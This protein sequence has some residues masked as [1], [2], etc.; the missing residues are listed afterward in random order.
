[1]KRTLPFNFFGAAFLAAGLFAESVSAQIRFSAGSP[2]TQ[3]FDS[4]GTV[5]NA[6]TDNITL[7]G[8]YASKTSGGATVTGYRADSGASNTGAL[9]SFGVTGVNPVTDRALGSVASGTPG[10]FAYGIRFQ[11]D[12][13]LAITNITLG[14]AGEQWRNGGNTA[15]QTLAFSYLISNNPI[16]SSDAANAT[17]WTAFSPLSFDSPTVGANAAALDGNAATNRQ[18]LAPTLLPG[19]VVFPG[20]EIF[21]RWYDINDAGNDH[22]MAVDDLTI[23]FSTVVAVTNPPAIGPGG[24]PQS[25]TNNAGTRAIF[26]VT[27]IGMPL[28]Y[29]WHLNGN[30]LMDGGKISGATSP[31]LTVSNVLSGD[32]GDYTVTVYNSADSV[33]SSNALLTV[34][35]PAVNTQPLSRTNIAGD[36]ASFSVTAAGTGAPLSYQWRFNGTDIPGANFSFLT[37]ESVQSTNQGGYTVVVGNND[38]T[39]SYTTSAVANLTLLATPVYN[40]ARWNFNETN[41]LVVTG[42]SAS[43][44]SGTASLVKGTTAGFTSGTSSDPAG[45]PGAANSGWNTTSYPAQ[46]TSNRTAGVQFKV[47]TVGYQD[48][49]V[50]WEQKHSA[51]AS[52]YA[53]LQYTTDGSSFVDGDLITMT[54]TNGDWVFYVS[55]LAAA[56]GVNN[57][58]NFAIRIVAEWE[59]TATGNNNSNYVGSASTYS[60][61]GTIRFDLLGV[62]GNLYHAPTLAPTTIRN[63][64][65]TTL[66]YSGGAGSRFV[67]LKSANVATALSVWERAH[68]NYA[69]PGTFT[70]P[71]GS[72]AAAFY[73]VKSE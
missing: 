20:Q 15:V 22:G 52:R 8:W 44:G 19:V 31:S 40:L 60:T 1:M 11:N 24:Q 51:T 18:V 28:N 67:L 6:W 4:L 13:T 64:L 53:R 45:A 57:N 73:R 55:N 62:Y 32:V 23:S 72:E 7:P 70:V 58:P 25:R 37:I 56:P 38:F 14:Y 47:S 71:A 34:I 69:T 12:T 9:C 61:G 50:A 21:F 41:V 66:S 16:T 54:A 68:T 29:Q 49:L 10:N 36:N 27:A 33:L 17:A 43:M 26:T 46:G 48:L 35:D 63:I 39:T 30:D 59:A 2:Y 42:P 65:G 5:S 3:N